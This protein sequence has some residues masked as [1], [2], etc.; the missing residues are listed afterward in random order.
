MDHVP[1]LHSPLREML[2]A[3]RA[4][5]PNVAADAAEELLPPAETDFDPT[6]DDAFSTLMQG[7]FYKIPEVKAVSAATRR[8]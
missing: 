6:E 1:A 7:L 4:K 2:A 8:R 3:N 5:A